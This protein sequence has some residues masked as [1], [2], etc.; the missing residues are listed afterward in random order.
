[1]AASPLST[2]HQS[3]CVRLLSG[4]VAVKN[5]FRFLLLLLA[6]FVALK[7]DRS[8]TGWFVDFDLTPGNVTERVYFVEVVETT[9]NLF[10]VDYVANRMEVASLTIAGDRASG[11]TSAGRGVVIQTVGFQQSVKLTLAGVERTVPFLSPTDTG[12]QKTYTGTMFPLGGIEAP[13]ARLSLVDQ[14]VIMF[15]ISESGFIGGGFGSLQNGQISFSLVNDIF[16]ELPFVPQN[17]AATGRATYAGTT[18]RAFDYLLVQRAAPSLVNIATLGKI[19]GG[20]NLIAGTVIDGPKRLLIRA[21]GPTLANFGVAT[22]HPNPRLKL[23]KGQAVLA[24]N[25]DWSGAEV[26]DAAVHVGAFAL[27]SGTKDAAIL[28]TLEQGAY[29]VIVEGDGELGEALVEVYE[30]K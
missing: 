27:A 19:G 17:G 13:V 28:I 20:T 21:V 1:M 18:N 30:V 25:D 4:I 10:L 7:A 2:L 15:W 22:A 11:I 12:N 6:S 26:S 16:L 9:V 24:S 8:N 14:R 3:L 5:L 23:F 29:T